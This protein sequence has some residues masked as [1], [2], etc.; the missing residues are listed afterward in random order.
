MTTHKSDYATHNAPACMDCGMPYDD[1]PMDTVL[2][3]DQWLAIN[4]NS[5][6]SK[7]DAGG[8]LCANCMVRRAKALPGAYS[9]R[10]QI[11]F[12]GN[13]IDGKDAGKS[14]IKDECISICRKML[15]DE[16][17][18]EQAFFDDCVGHAIA[19]VKD[20]RAEIERLRVTS[21]DPGRPLPKHGSGP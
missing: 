12:K 4:P 3:H 21:D 9:T 2:P 14:D 20:A 5:D 6:D 10:M 15:K 13:E 19:M 11:A 17:G 8:L 1:F 16:L 7:D 18:I